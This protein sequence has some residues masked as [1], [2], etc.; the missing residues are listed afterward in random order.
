M[1]ILALTKYSQLGASSRL[2]VFQYLDYLR[3]RGDE[4][5]EA[6]LLTDQYLERLYSGHRPKWS[7]LVA[8]YVR[9]IRELST[10]VGRFDLI[11]MEKELFPWVPA[12]L[13]QLF[14]SKRVPC[15]VDY[16][17]AI[18]QQYDNHWA[19]PI[20]SML[21][22]K[23]DW[24]MAHADCVIAGNEYLASRARRAGARHVEVLPT[25]VD[26]TRYVPTSLQAG[27]PLTIGWIG[28]PITAKYLELIAPALRLVHEQVPIR[29]T[30]IGSGDLDLGIPV[31]AFPWSENTEVE[32]LNKFHVGIMPLHDGPVERGK[33]GYKLIQCMAVGRTV[34]GSPVGANCQ[35]IQHGVNGYL[36]SSTKDWTDA[37]LKLCRDFRLLQ[38]M[39]V[40]ARRTV[41]SQY[42]TQR[43]APRLA[44]ILD[45]V[46]SESLLKQEMACPC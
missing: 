29:L 31:Q 34:V 35:I 2:R 16:D 24:V 14:G 27:E 42:C 26:L 1:R 7:Q 40:S 46:A 13:E 44:S 15:V 30:T 36:A 33:C 32:L 22:S 3:A 18:F 41:E 45:R 10:T 20:R 9:R 4:V 43:T 21:G 8:G 5:T 11:W 12:P 25:A 6:P 28:T 17:D 38:D 23:I 19:L 37:L 39:G